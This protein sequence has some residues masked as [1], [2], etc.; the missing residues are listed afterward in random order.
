VKF[1]LVPVMRMISNAVD[2]TRAVASKRTLQNLMEAPNVSASIPTA[3]TLAKSPRAAITVT[4]TGCVSTARVLALKD[5]MDSGANA[6]SPKN[7]ACVA[8]VAMKS[9]RAPVNG[10]SPI[11]A[12]KSACAISAARISASTSVWPATTNHPPRR[13]IATAGCA[14]GR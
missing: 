14:S 8:N 13:T 2:R 11:T 7:L 5:T 9:A 3:V 4:A 12:V 1:Q 10:N 6:K